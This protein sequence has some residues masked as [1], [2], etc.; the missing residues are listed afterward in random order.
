MRVPSGLIMLA[1]SLSLSLSFLF[2]Q[3][4]FS[5]YRASATPS[6]AA[7]D[8]YKYPRNWGR[9][10]ARQDVDGGHFRVLG[11]WKKRRSENTAALFRQYSREK[12]ITRVAC[13]RGVQKVDDPPLHWWWNCTPG[14]WDGCDPERD[15]PASVIDTRSI[16][17]I[18]IE[19]VTCLLC[20]V[21]STGP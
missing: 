11:R 10:G 6:T 12:G 21:N 19:T 1:V 7:V 5:F 16:I 2:H 3:L 14:W 9:G 8:A 18:V 20:Y 13:A 4:F 17:F 15:S